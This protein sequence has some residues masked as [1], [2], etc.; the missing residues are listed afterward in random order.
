MKILI[1]F[2]FLKCFEIFEILK[3][4]ENFERVV[5]LVRHAMGCL[6]GNNRVVTR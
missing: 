3:C 2:K 5:P 4:F 1:F 6:P